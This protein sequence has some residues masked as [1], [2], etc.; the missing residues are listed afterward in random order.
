MND[1][2]LAIGSV[3][4]LLAGCVATGGAPGTG[5]ATKASPPSPTP[6]ATISQATDPAGI[7]P[8]SSETPAPPA[9]PTV[10][11]TLDAAVC[12]T[13]QL[14]AGNAGWGGATGSLLGGFLVWNVGASPCRLPGLPSVAIVDATGR[15]LSVTAA[16]AASPRG[17]P[18][19]L[20][21]GRSAPA[22]HQEPPS[23]LASETFQWFNW[24]AAA[25][26]GPLSLAV[27][28]PDVGLLRLPIVFDGGDT[29][30]PRCDDSAAP[31]T[32]TVSAFEETPGPAPTEPPTVPA[33]GLRLALDVPDEATAGEALHYIAALTNPTT[34]AIALTP[35][36]AYRESL[37][38][39]SGQLT[40]EL[41]LG[42]A[43]ATSVAPGETVRFAMLFEI[44]RSQ[45]ATADAALVWELDPYHSEGFLP[46]GPAQKVVVRIIA[47]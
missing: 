13:D 44:P 47:P 12:R 22:L 10:T 29:S 4:L 33:E 17:Q 18:I 16:T 40:A 42:C 1:R 34:S 7:V 20:G 36:P 24:C 21:P 25:P 28:L 35:C 23:G 9:T 8:W 32:L 46:R 14:A 5:L 30:A 27:T 26:K 45:P 19:V 37:V 39:Q 15:A 31:S 3:A 11:P 38:T 2:R 43:A 41:V 6:A